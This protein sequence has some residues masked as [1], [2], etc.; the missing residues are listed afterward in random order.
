[1]LIATGAVDPGSSTG[2]EVETGSAEMEL[3]FLIVGV[4]SEGACWPS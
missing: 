3:G 4:C 1:M 2:E